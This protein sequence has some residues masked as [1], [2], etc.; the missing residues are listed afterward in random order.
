MVHPHNG[1]L[2][3]NKKEQTAVHTTAQRNLESILLSKRRQTVKIISMQFQTS[4]DRNQTGDGQGLW[5]NEE[6][7]HK[8]TRELS[9]VMEMFHISIVVG[10]ILEEAF[11]KSHPPVH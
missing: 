11:V 9:A 10:L 1:A 8:G 6:I 5:V 4:R 2:V 7:D 3:S